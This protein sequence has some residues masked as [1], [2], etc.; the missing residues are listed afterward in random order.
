MLILFFSGAEFHQFS[1]IPYLAMSYSHA[2]LKNTATRSRLLR[3][4]VL[5]LAQI[6]DFYGVLSLTFWPVHNGNII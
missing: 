4:V 6:V 2:F 5:V 3:K 1:Q